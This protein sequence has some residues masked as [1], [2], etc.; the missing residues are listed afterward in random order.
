V[1]SRRNH[2]CAKR[3]QRVGQV[4]IAPNEP[5]DLGES[6]APNE[7][8]DSAESIAPN[9]PNDLAESIAPNELSCAFGTPDPMKMRAS[10]QTPVRGFSEQPDDLGESIAPDEPNLEVPV[11]CDELFIF[12]RILCHRD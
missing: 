3:T 9:E 10:T 12:A 5:N 4:S 6:I 1:L 8:N 2:P 11:Y 7:P